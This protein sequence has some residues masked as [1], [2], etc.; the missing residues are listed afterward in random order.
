MKITMLGTGNALV[1]EY[2]NTCY[3][4]D[5]G[6]KCVLVDGGGGSHVLHQLAHAG[7]RWQDMRDIIVT[8][9]HIDHLFGVIWMMRLI[10]ES[11]AAGRYDGE[12]RIYGHDEVIAMLKDLSGKL[13]KKKEVKF[14]GSRL[15]LIEVHDG[16]TREIQDNAYT[17]FDIGSTKLKQYGYCLRLA[18]GRKITCCG[19]EPCSEGGRKY[20]AGSDWLFH[21][22]FCLDGQADIYH[23]YEKHHT[24]V[25]NAGELAES[26]QVQNLL[27]Y[28]TEDG[29]FGKRKELYTE[30]CRR[31]YHGGVFVPDDL[32]T[33]EL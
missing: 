4:L 31:Y 29:T 7:Y 9:N 16:E 30:E 22:A 23:P 2:Y 19:D 8:H 5:D 6:G 3:V 32:E 21:E 1:S 33:I 13:L 18:D 12:A 27:L 20:A 15:H 11:M 10:L 28:H 14:I 24:T 17:F 25:K 26:L